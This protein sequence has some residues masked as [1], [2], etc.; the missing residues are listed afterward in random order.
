MR[1]AMRA[2]HAVR[3]DMTS[4]PRAPRRRVAGGGGTTLRPLTCVTEAAMPASCRWC[5]DGRE[6]GPGWTRRLPNAVSCTRCRQPHGHPVGPMR[7]MHDQPTQ[8]HCRAPGLQG[9]RP[10]APRGH[11]I[12]TV[13]AWPIGSAV[14]CALLPGHPL[15]RW[16]GPSRRHRGSGVHSI[17]TDSLLRAR[18]R[19]AL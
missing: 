15:Q 3:A 1:R 11:G 12:V 10:P 5:S 4:R 13:L 19:S 6:C 2:V 14:R 7:R 8:Q 17:G 18:G 9:A 16:C